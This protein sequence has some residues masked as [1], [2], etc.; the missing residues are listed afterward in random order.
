LAATIYLPALYPYQQR[1][2]NDPAR[3][4]CTV[5]ATQVGKT[6]A[7]AVW[8][9]VSAMTRGNRTHPWWWIAPTFSQIAQGFKLALAFASSAGMVQA[10]TVSPFPIIKLVNGA[11][12]EFRSWEREQN[13][14]GTTIGG[15]VVDEAGLLTNEAQGIIST[16]RSATLGPLRY[17]GNPGVVAGPFRRLCA[18]GEQAATP[19]N[20]WTGTFSLHRWTWRDKHEA[21][22][23][24]DADRAFQYE[25]FIE[26]ERR[27]IPD[28]EFRRLYEAEWTEDEA[29][30]FRGLDA[31]IDRTGAG[32]LAAGTDRFVIGVDVAQSVDYLAAVSWA[33]NAHRLELR[34]RAR[35]IPYAQA[36]QT[37]K[38]LSQEL[39]APLIVEENGPGVALIQE[40]ARLEVPVYPFTTTSQSKQEVILNLAADIQGG[41]DRCVVSDHSPLP[42]ELAMYR[43]ERGTTGMYRYSAPPGEHDDTVMAAALARWGAARCLYD[44]KDYGWI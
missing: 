44:L 30:V 5:S 15:G 12:I 8:I 35:G 11:T 21:L 20:E 38:A 39:S 42:H 16:R 29:A 22:L 3:D 40:L 6:Y 4:A 41:P 37:L 36:A 18:L 31:C 10:S 33:Q 43:Y 2:L 9:V 24:A 17:I 14:A 34:Y 19:G 25:R 23:L 26:Q 1:L 27:S 32:L 28:F 13:L 7:L